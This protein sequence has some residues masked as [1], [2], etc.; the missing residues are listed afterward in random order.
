M[1]RFIIG[2]SLTFIIGILLLMIVGL[3]QGCN[4]EKDITD[5]GNIPAPTL[6][7]IDI[8]KI[9]AVA[10]EDIEK[11]GC[12]AMFLSERGGYIWC[13]CKD[14]NIKLYDLRPLIEKYKEGQLKAE[15]SK[16]ETGG[17][18]K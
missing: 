15:E 16:D 4:E 3:V 2:S 18:Y 17:D 14:K 6:N 13:R 12:K 1:K 9:L 11:Q 7:Q 5:V 8:A 10:V